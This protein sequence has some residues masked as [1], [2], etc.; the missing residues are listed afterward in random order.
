MVWKQMNLR[1]R[2]NKTPKNDQCRYC[3]ETGHMMTGCPKL[4]K[5]LKHEDPDAEK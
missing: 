3:K 4:A 2:P 5:Q 1:S